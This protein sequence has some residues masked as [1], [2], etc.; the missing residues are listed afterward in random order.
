MTDEA[1]PGW[2]GKFGVWMIGV[3]KKSEWK[4]HL[5]GTDSYGLTFKPRP[6]RKGPQLV[7]APDAVPDPRQSVGEGEALTAPEGDPRLVGNY[8]VVALGSLVSQSDDDFLV[9]LVME[10][11]GGSANPTVVRAQIQRIRAE[12]ERAVA[13]TAV[14]ATPRVKP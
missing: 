2:P 4:C 6:R 7:L 5:F 8:N 9:G 1:T 14:A 13:N 3:P 10:L 11:T 12:H